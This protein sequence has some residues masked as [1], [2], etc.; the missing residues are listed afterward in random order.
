MMSHFSKS[1]YLETIQTRYL[2]SIRKEK[3]AILN[4]FCQICVYNRKYATRILNKSPAEKRKKPGKAAIYQNHEFIKHLKT[5]WLASNQPCSKRLK[6]VIG[7]WLPFYKKQTP[8][9]TECEKLLSQISPATIDRLLKPIRVRFK[10][11]G[12]SGTKPG[13]LLKNHIPIRTENWDIQKP[14]WLEA[15]TVHHCGNS[16]RGDY[17]YSLTMTDIVSGWTENR[18]IWGKSAPAVLNAVRSI[19]ASLPFPLKGFDSDNGSEFLNQVLYEYFQGLDHSVAFTRSRPY[20]KNDNAHVEQKNWTHVREWLGYDRFDHLEL[21]EL[22]NDFYTGPA[23]L[24][25]NFFLPNLKLK[26][27][28]RINS[29]YVKKYEIPKT[30]FQRLIESQHVSD[31]Q[32]QKLQTVF[33]SLNPFDLKEDM[34]KKLK[35][36][37][38]TKKQLN[39]TQP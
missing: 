33:A 25:Q 13:T 1:Q 18:A 16:L 11:R 32:K 36:I 19:Q 21:V 10:G 7:I 30:P 38:D 26:E 20:K 15:D 4:E 3:S 34:E 2:T 37:F 39:S 29:K 6:I 27:K 24:L 35:K 23:R 5:L 22:V 12:L 31:F 14:G 17:I 8:L 9:P 28:I